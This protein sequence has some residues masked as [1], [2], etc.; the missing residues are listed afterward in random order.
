M[1]EKLHEGIKRL[2]AEE[3]PRIIKEGYAFWA[4]EMEKL[5]AEILKKPV[6]QDD[7]PKHTSQQAS[8][9]SDSGV[10]VDI[11]VKN[12]DTP[13]T[14]RKLFPLQ[15]EGGVLKIKMIDNLFVDFGEE[16]KEAGKPAREDERCNTVVEKKT[17]E[18]V[19]VNAPDT[20]VCKLA[21]GTL[22][23]IVA[24]AAIDKVINLDGGEQTIH[25]VRLGEENAR[26]SITEVIQGD[27]RIP[28]PIGD[29]ILTVEQAIGTFIAWPRNLIVAGTNTA[30]NVLAAPKKSKIKKTK[31]TYKVLKHVE[32][33]LTVEMGANYPSALNRLWTWAKV[34]LAHGETV[35]FTLCKEAFGSTK[36]HV[37]YLSDIYA[38]C[39]G[40][41]MSGSV[42]CLFI[43]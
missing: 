18:E 19:K 13:Q 7:T 33:E 3:T 42:I 20:C 43:Q 4:T 11:D 14:A 35:S 29:E 12:K 27:A 26:V 30:S 37:I 40:G 39:T 6:E 25:G 23:N 38:V 2:M 17:S 22:N 24:C 10:A 31:K 8:C 32:P 28:F 16:L 5:R 9:H 15:E 36:K 21:V 1:D 34:A 41:E